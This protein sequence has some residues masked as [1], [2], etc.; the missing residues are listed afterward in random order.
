[1][2][3]NIFRFVYRFSKREQIYILILTGSSF[4]F[5]YLS[6]DLPKTI[7]N[8]AIGGADFPVFVLGFELEQVP[9]LFTLSG[10]FLVLVVFNGAFKYF[11]NVYRG[12]LGERMLRRLRYELYS[13]VLRF[14]LPRFK[15]MSQGEIAA[16]PKIGLCTKMNAR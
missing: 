5:L 1:M 11:I 15:R 10:M 6:L 4:P 13:R 2:D 9:Y 8:D 14:R 7:V 16:A 3:K 12:Q